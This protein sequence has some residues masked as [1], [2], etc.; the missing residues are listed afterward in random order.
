M[1]AWQ[2][3]RR[4]GPSRRASADRRSSATTRAW[5]PVGRGRPGAPRASAA[6][7]RSGSGP[8][9]ASAP[10]VGGERPALA[11]R[12]FRLDTMDTI[13][14]TPARPRR[15]CRSCPLRTRRRALGLRRGSPGG[16]CPLCLL[17]PWT[18]NGRGRHSGSRRERPPERGADRVGG[19]RAPRPT[20][21]FRRGQQPP[22]IHQHRRGVVDRFGRR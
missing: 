2:A 20:A 17:C 15:S 8:P 14:K 9:E 19:P 18:K 12:R 16:L 1:A 13:D 6:S 10:G 7:A 11:I 21:A 22:G 5:S 4:V 3:R